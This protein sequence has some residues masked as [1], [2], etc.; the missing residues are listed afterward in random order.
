M[1]PFQI[2]NPAARAVVAITLLTCSI[3]T[4][5]AA[6]GKEIYQQQ[7]IACHG[8]K[9]LG[10]GP[11]AKSLTSPPAS[12]LDKAIRLSAERAVMTGVNNVP[13][14]GVGQLLTPRE[15]ESLIEYV[16]GLSKGKV[17]AD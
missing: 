13:G 17:G 14:H 2:S 4:A 12:F 11:H 15:I 9:G 7:C 16:D 3:G 6:S 5:I 8:A 10:D 1:R